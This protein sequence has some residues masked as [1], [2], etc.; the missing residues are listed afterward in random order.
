MIIL[1]KLK[2]HFRGLLFKIWGFVPLPPL[3]APILI[4]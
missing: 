4:F 2:Y 1:M 3:L